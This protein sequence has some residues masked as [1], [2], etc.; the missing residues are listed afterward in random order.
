M[1]LPQIQAI[2]ATA[3]LPSEIHVDCSL[4]AYVNVRFAHK[5]RITIK[6]CSEIVASNNLKNSM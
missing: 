3:K 1:K 2:G 6:S 5:Q 4:V